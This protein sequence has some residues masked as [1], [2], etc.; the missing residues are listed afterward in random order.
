MDVARGSRL[1]ARG[2][3]TEWGVKRLVPKDGVELKLAIRAGK[4]ATGQPGR[5]ARGDG[6]VRCQFS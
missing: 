2:S 3:W 5:G 4:S 1:A 6:K